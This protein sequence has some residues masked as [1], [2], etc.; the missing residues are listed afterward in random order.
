MRTF[1]YPLVAAMLLAVAAPAAGD[2]LAERWGNDPTCRHR[3][4]VTYKDRVLTFDLSA[5]PKGAKVYRAVFKPTVR[6]RGHVGTVEFCPL[7]ERPDKDED[8]PR[9]GAPLKLRPPLY[10]TF[11]A[12]DLVRRWVADPSKNLGLYVK[13]APGVRANNVVLEVSY[14]GRVAE[15]VPAVTA[16]TALHQAGQTFLTWKEIE[17][18]IGSDA[19][20]FEEFHNRIVAARQKR[21][22]VY[23]VYRSSK[24]ITP[25]TLGEAELVTEVPEILTCWNLKAVSNTEHADQGTPTMKSFLRPG[26]NNARNHVMTRYRI[27]DGGDP[28]PSATALAV[29]TVT[30]PGR[31]HYAVTASVDGAEAVRALGR[32]RRWPRPSMRP[33]ASFPR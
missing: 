23:N 5:V 33:P 9:L 26:Y 27:I 7:L 15:P 12:T 17:D 10:R 31:R 22:V 3:G 1:A 4:T 28:L 25:A 6:H 32:G 11:D 30:K 24:P 18:P 16:L 20:K 8:E 21:S 29:I 2:Y 14:E 19:P 13:R